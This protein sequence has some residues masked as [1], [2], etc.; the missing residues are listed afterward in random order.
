MTLRSIRAV[1]LQG[2]E[3]GDTSEVI[4]VFSAECGRLSVMAKGIRAAK[5][6]LRGIMQP[7]ATVDLNVYLRDDSGMGT[8]RDGATV[9]ER[10]EIRDDLE[11]LAL[12]SMLAEIAA[13][14]CEEAQESRDL[15]AVLEAGL[16]ALDPGA[17]Q[18]PNT[19]ALHHLLRLIAVAGYEPDI[20]AGLLG[21]WP[22]NVP[23]PR[24]F[25]LSLADGRIHADVHQPATGPEWP[26]FAADG[27]REV[28]LPPECVRALY[29]NRHTESDALGGLPNLPA[30]KAVQ[31]IDALVRLVQWHTGHGIRSARFWRS[32]IR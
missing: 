28:L 11:R 10:M 8:L 19:A 5:S 32:V 7:L 13:E 30:E 9:R 31:F 2:Y 21:A 14:S 29:E 27:A 3:T 17:P 25:A 1:V 4:R 6:R 23:R 16:D 26:L 20:D 22:A 24:V 18:S 12:A 15:F